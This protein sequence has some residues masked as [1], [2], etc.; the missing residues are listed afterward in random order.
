MNSLVTVAWLLLVWALGWLALPLSSRLWRGALADGGLAAGRVLLLCL[1]TMGAFWA[2]N[3]GLPVRWSAMAI[4]PV[5]IGLAA[6]CWRDRERLASHIDRHRG[7]IRQSEAFFLIVFTLFFVLRGYMPGI[8]NGEKPMDMALISACARADN[9]PPANPYAAGTRLESYYYLG[10][11]Q[12]ALL[13]ESIGTTPRWSYNLMCATLPAL[14]FSL[15]VALAAG[16]N[17]GLAGGGLATLLVLCSGTLQPFSQWLERYR[18]GTFSLNGELPFWSLDYM[19]TSRVIPYTINEYPWF[20]FNYAD[21]H[22]HYFGMPLALLALSLGWALFN[23]VRSAPASLQCR[24]I[25][26]S[27]ALVLGSQI[28]TNTWDFPVYGIYFALC[29]SALILPR[30]RDAGEVGHDVESELP[31]LS[32][33]LVTTGATC[34]A[35][36]ICAVSLAAPFLLR[37]HSEAN[38][39]TPL[40]QP[41]S[42]TLA[43]LMMWGLPAGAW[44]LHLV[45]SAQDRGVGRKAVMALIA[46]AVL[47]AA[48]RF[49]TGNDHFVLIFIVLLAAWSGCEIVAARNTRDAW[50]ARLAFCGC[51]ALLWS[52]TTWAGFLGSRDIRAFD[53]YKR[54]DTVFKFGLQAWYLLGIPAGLAAVHL[55]RRASPSKGNFSGPAIVQWFVF[56]W[57]RVPLRLGTLLLPVAVL[58]SV[59]VVCARADFFRNYQLADAWVYL[60]PAERGAAAWLSSH[61][62]DGDYLVEAEMLEGGDYSEYTRYT[63]ATG[64]PAVIG[65]KAHTFQWGSTWSEV[66][67]RKNAVRTFYLGEMVGGR[68][69]DEARLAL[70]RRYRVR[71]VVCGVLERRQYGSEAVADVERLLPETVYDEGQGEE[72]VSIR[73]LR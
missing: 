51:L 58:A 3:L 30:N 37:L 67:E 70:M 34:I 50:M 65:P 66:D 45:V 22:A 27:G 47:W 57:Y 4:Y 39:P 49:K 17:G 68:M 48:L 28:I 73:L 64:V 33:R 69:P 63:H 61:A 43:W 56:P 24:A 59:S 2:G 44:L 54:Q 35:L 40:P 26:A 5:L 16:V 11:L 6:L 15:L 19:A 14:C 31:S 46:T 52:E 18:V 13:T 10:H 41:G 12:T 38:R 7:G 23:C 21:L 53:D 9:L 29:L 60:T 71:Y 36:A 72:R 8:D 55:W 25:V 62:V 42:P 1:W 32:N 20:T